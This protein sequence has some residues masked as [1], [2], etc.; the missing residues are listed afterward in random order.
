MKLGKRACAKTFHR[1]RLSPLAL[2]VGS[3]LFSGNVIAEE[4]FNPAFLTDGRGRVADLSG[5]EDGN[6]QAAGVYRVDIFLNNDFISSH[7]VDFRSL[8]SVGAQETSDDGTGLVACLS[9]KSLTDMGMELNLPEEKKQSESGQCTDISSLIEGAKASFDFAHQRLDLSVPQVALKNVARGYIPPEKWD[10]GISALLMNYTFTG[11]SSKDNGSS[12]NSQFLGL[13]GGINVGPW[14]LRDYSTFSRNTNS[15]TAASQ[16]DHVSSFIERAIIPLKGELT[17]GDS[18]TTGDVFDSVSFRGVQI[19]SDDNMLP[20]SLKGFAPT[21][22]G[23]AKSNAQ[24]T[25]KQNNYVLY[26]TYVAPGAFAIDDLFPTSSSGDLTVEI[27]EKD[28]SLTT[29][30]VPYSAVPL[31]QREGRIKYALTVANYRTSNDQQEQSP[32]GQGTIIWGAPHGLTLYGG[33]QISQ[34]Y[35]SQAVGAGIN[36]GGW[37]AVSADITHAKSTLIDDSQHSGHSLRLLYAK[38]LNDLGTNFQLLGYRYSTSGYYTFEDTTYQSM[39][40]YKN[41]PEES[42]DNDRPRWFDYY[43][44]YYTKRGKIQVNISQQLGKTGSMYLN[45]SQQTYWHT[46][47]KDTLVQLGYNTTWHDI[48][49]GVSYSYS[50]TYGQPEAD[51]VMALN[52]SLPLNKWLTPEGTARRNSTYATMSMS[53]DNHGSVTQNAGIS[54]TLLEGNNLT[55]SVQQGYVNQGS[56]YSGSVGLSHQGGYGN[57]NMGYNVSGKGESRQLTYGIAG[58]VVAHRHGITFSQP[59]GD[60]NVLIEAPGAKQVK[61]QNATGVSTDWRGYAVV[62]FATTYRKNRIALDT[63]T[64]SD[65]VDLDGAVVDVVPTKGALV[66][67]SFKARVG[68]RALLTLKHNDIAIPFGSTVS[69][70][71][72]GSA[73][74]A[75]D[76]GQVYLSGLATKGTLSARW[77]DGSDQRCSVNYQLPESAEN[78]VVTQLTLNCR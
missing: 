60:T 3:C 42:E 2:T 69:R 63:T 54:G 18:Y 66:S 77:G 17:I 39:S 26:Q 68:I 41:D 53:K 48:N 30:T 5:F 31:L 43:N 47:S 37:G 27:K 23:I 8:R 51:K 45:G 15:G 4:Y 16:W 49:I 73:G 50:K 34:R 71:D 10:E 64:L 29:Y 12:N 14:R 6:V 19:A 11:S 28:G 78:A 72:D 52:V 57:S 70:D 44:L 67:A 55:Y 59:L 9:P 36:M 58:G 24:V 56:G 61:I 1:W 76:G 38:S 33:T 65:K 35:R 46:D 20:D 74:I 21:V 40:G 7:D 25:I 62:P 32:F 75:G 13:N 22:R